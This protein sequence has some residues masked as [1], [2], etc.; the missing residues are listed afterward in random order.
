V[1]QEKKSLINKPEMQSVLLLYRGIDFLHKL[2]F[3]GRGSIDRWIQNNEPRSKKQT[4]DRTRS[5]KMLRIQ[6]FLYD[7]DI[8]SDNIVCVGFLKDFIRFR[9]KDPS[10]I[11][12]DSKSKKR[13]IT[14]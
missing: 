10:K 13:L 1:I 12:Q 4:S 14:D 9:L 3:M 2:I 7:L 8:R 6:D 5:D 11:L